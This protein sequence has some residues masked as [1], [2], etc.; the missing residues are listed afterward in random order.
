MHAD[1]LTTGPQLLTDCKPNRRTGK[2]ILA[3][4]KWGRLSSLPFRAFVFEGDEMNQ[5][6][7]SETGRLESLPHPAMLLRALRI[8]SDL[9]LKNL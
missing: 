9:A 2:A 3:E 7:F 1:S 6:N 8:K 4:I 5:R